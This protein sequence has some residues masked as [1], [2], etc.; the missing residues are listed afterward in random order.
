MSKKKLPLLGTTLYVLAG[1]L[2]LYT[3]WA[4]IRSFDYIFNMV[5]QNRLVI[6]EF[7][8]ANFHL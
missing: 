7:E 1:L 8:I 3:I 6:S 2:T 4:A 5:A